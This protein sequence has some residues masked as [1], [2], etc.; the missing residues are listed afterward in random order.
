MPP[1]AVTGQ[2]DVD[3]RTAG[4]LVPQNSPARSEER[5]E[6]QDARYVLF[7]FR[8]VISTAQRLRAEVKRE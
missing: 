4:S 6:G 1:G 3:L 7:R 5:N 8:T 2:R